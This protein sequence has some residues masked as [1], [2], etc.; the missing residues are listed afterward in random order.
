M[1]LNLLLDSSLGKQQRTRGR[2][3]SND[4]HNKLS[5]AL[6]ELITMSYSW[7]NIDASFG[8]DKILF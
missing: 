3:V 2:Q 8:N 4:F 1:S 7:Y 5:E 6:D